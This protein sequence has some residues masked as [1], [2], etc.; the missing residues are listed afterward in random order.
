MTPLIHD[1]QLANMSAIENGSA[2]RMNRTRSHS[3]SDAPILPTPIPM[4]RES[5]S[6]QSQSPLMSPTSPSIASSSLSA[7]LKAFAELS[8]SPPT[9]LESA[10]FQ[11]AYK[12]A[13]STSFSSSTNRPNY[14][15]PSSDAPTTAATTMPGM[16][17]SPTSAV[18]DA[19]PT[20]PSGSPPRQQQSTVGIPMKPARGSISGASAK[21]AASQLDGVCEKEELEFEGAV[22]MGES[23]PAASSSA[24]LFS[25]GARW[26]WPAS[27]GSST[28]TVTSPV[29]GAGTSPPLSPPLSTSASSLGRR[30]SLPSSAGN[31]DPS[32][33]M[34]PLGRV[35]SAGSTAPAGGK[36][37]DGFGLFRR[38]S[39]GGFG[40][41]GRVSSRVNRL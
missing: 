38:L 20:P 13:R 10:E 2:S 15:A 21:G 1:R 6:G 40:G 36:G 3:V 31:R 18:S 7:S 34:A 30:P 14:S 17:T 8:L 35:V 16:S 27:G 26:G 33:M 11:K 22:R 5:M 41:G 32:T 9:T 4:R 12:H 23:A 37:S 29:I 25:N 39:V 24:A 19:L 28:S